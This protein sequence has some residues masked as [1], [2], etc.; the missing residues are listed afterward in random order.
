M[1]RCGSH[2]EGLAS[3]KRGVY[4]MSMKV[5]EEKQAEIPVTEAVEET[6][7]ERLENLGLSLSSAS[8]KR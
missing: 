2:H 3:P 4:D 8:S 6:V 1:R 5:T 7:R